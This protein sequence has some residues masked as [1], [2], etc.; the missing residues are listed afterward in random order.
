[1]LRQEKEQVVKEIKDVVASAEFLVLLAHN[2][3]SVA[4]ITRLRKELR[5]TNGNLRV[6]KNNLFKMAVD[7]TDQAFL[8]KDMVGPFAMMW[9]KEDPVGVAKAFKAFVKD[10]PKV[11]VKTAMLGNKTLSVEDVANLANMPPLDVAK[12]QFVGLLASVPGKFLRLL[13]TPMTNFGYLLSAR[14]DQLEQA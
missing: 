1:M 10:V 11:E 9:T 5:E 8:A 13:N 7:N 6:I 12:A 2:G 3:L 14:R 4:E